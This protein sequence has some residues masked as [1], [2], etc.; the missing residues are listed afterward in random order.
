MNWVLYIGVSV[1]VLLTIYYLLVFGRLWVHALKMPSVP[2]FN[3]PV[4]II[5]CAYNEA[6]NLSRNL[7]LILE[8]DYA[9][10]FEVVV[11]DD[12]STD[13]TAELLGSLKLKYPKLKVLHFTAPKRSYGKKEALALGLE[14]A[15]YD[16]VLLTDADCYPAGKEWLSRMTGPLVQKEV[17]LGYGGYSKEA[18]F[19]N[20]LLRWETLQTVLHYMSLALLGKPY[21]GVG[22]NL[23]Y[24]LDLFRSG[25][26]FTNHEH[27]ASGDDDLFVAEVAIASNVD[28]VTDS[29]AFTWSHGPENLKTWW[30]QKRRHLPTGS[31]YKKDI[32][33]IL[34]GDSALTV[35]FYISLVLGFW[36]LPGYYPF[37]IIVLCKVL[38]QLFI[39]IPLAKRFRSSELM[40]LFPFWEFTVTLLLGL[41][42]LQN[43]WRGQPEKW[44]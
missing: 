17:V 9:A 5:I 22:R 44:K 24:K 32:Q 14:T 33:W 36:W 41:I 27:L 25:T 28:I 4:S 10:D 3:Q 37:W 31:F 16:H 1:S 18:H 43:L 19:T 13:G 30:R 12:H 2:R 23:A 39:F 29:R 15:A 26:G 34:A 6:S 11:V 8:Q 20:K 7:P 21:M 40:W 42:H 38:V 35:L